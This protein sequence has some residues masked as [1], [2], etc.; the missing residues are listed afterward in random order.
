M[1]D[2]LSHVSKTIEDLRRQ[3]VAKLELARSDLAV[4]NGLEASFGLSLTTFGEL[5]AAPS[6]ATSTTVNGQSPLGVSSK[7]QSPG[8]RGAV[9]PDEYLA[10]EPMEAAKK[11]M[12]SIGHAIH[13]DEIADAVQ[14]GG[15]AIQGTNWRDRLELSLKRSP[16]Q[17]IMV[18]DKTYGLAEF[19]TPD[20]L[21]RF[22]SSRRGGDDVAPGKKPKTKKKTKKSATPVGTKVKSQPGT[23]GATGKDPVKSEAHPEGPEQTH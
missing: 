12:R 11:Y 19:Y 16:Y 5:A 17:V 3:V 1:A 10:E 6:G 7:N 18:A 9:R 21:K 4:I 22:R 8:R 20:Q 2:D 14:S 23:K 13:F 15:A